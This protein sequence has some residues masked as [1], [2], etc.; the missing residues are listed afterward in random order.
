MLAEIKNNN[1]RE[2]LKIVWDNT[3]DTSRRNLLN[4]VTNDS[5]SELYSMLHS[6]NSNE[7][8][9]QRE[10]LKV[11]SFDKVK[12]LYNLVNINN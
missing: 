9:R 5:L 1:D 7:T 3:D 6:N 4:A 11:I 12:D 2:S 10:L 8:D